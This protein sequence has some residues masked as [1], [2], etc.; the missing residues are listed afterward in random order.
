MTSQARPQNQDQSRDGKAEIAFRLGEPEVAKQPAAYFAELRDR[1]PVAHTDAH[2]GFWLLSRY[3]DVREA[4]MNAS[5]VSSAS[6]VTIPPAPNPPSLCLEQDEPEHRDW[7]R[8]MQPWFSPQRIRKMEAAV[9]AIVTECIDEV[10]DDGRADLAEAIAAPVPALVIGSILGLPEEDWPFFRAKNSEYFRLGE[11]GDYQG[12][13]AAV[14]ELVGYLSGQLE[15]RKE[16]PT[17]DLLTDI[18]NVKVADRPVN[19]EE[20]I[21][22]SFLLLAAGHETT[23]G[24]LGGMLYHVARDRQLRDHLITDPDAISKAVEEAL[25]LE[26]PLP[27]L[28]RMTREPLTVN[29]T[30]IPEAERVMLLFAAANR[31]PDVFDNPED[32]RLDR[33]TNHHLAFGYGIHRCVGAPLARLEMQIV[34]EEVLRRMPGLHLPNESDVSV[35]YAFSRSFSN[36]K[37]AW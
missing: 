37:A 8:Q 2:G 21:S 22:L 3:D 16:T 13:M 4:A 24:A 36:L 7:R 31:D 10:I 25:R 35:S 17:D 19:G 9:R 1:C 30:E 11:Q 15:S 28:G 12:A 18:L 34:L 20:A 6:G 32:F 5:V 26:P 27:G 14:N 29:G 33:A 23:V